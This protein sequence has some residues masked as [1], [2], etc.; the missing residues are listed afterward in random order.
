M[1]GFTETRKRCPHCDFSWLDKYGKNECPKCCQPLT[2]GHAPGSRPSWSTSAYSSS[3]VSGNTAQH[4]IQPG[5]AS[6]YKQSASSAMESQS[7]SCSKGGAHTWK[8]GKCSKCG[9][10]EGYA[11]GGAPAPVRKPSG[12][13]VTSCAEG[14]HKFKFAKCVNC[15]KREY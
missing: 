4:R 1:S 2:T 13:G 5:E 14:M 9:R 15:G 11:H 12:T 8:F 6:T 10:A 3:Q 7:G